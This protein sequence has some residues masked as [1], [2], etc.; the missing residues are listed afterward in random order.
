MNKVPHC[1]ECEYLKMY[2]YIYK[3]YYCDNEDRTDDMGKLGVDHPPKTSPKWCPLRCKNE[4]NIDSDL[5]K[6][7]SDIHLTGKE[8]N[9][10]EVKVP[11]PEYIPEIFFT[12]SRR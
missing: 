8:D 9:P 12:K 1:S 7:K 6:V 3:N 11:E 5:I 10:I 2:D 4:H